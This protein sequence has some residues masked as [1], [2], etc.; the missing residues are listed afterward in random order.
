VA[1]RAQAVGQKIL[2]ALSCRGGAIFRSDFTGTN[3]LARILLELQGAKLRVLCVGSKR[4]A[5]DWRCVHVWTTVIM[6]L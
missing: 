5:S 1:D 3:Q 4:Q 2:Q 6:S